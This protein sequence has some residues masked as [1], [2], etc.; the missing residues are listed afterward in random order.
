[1]EALI[2]RGAAPAAVRG[3][4]APGWEGC[5]ELRSA[6]AGAHCPR[7]WPPREG[8]GAGSH[9]SPPRQRWAVLSFQ[10]RVKSFDMPS[11]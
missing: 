2:R 8:E 4:R 7:P 9:V 6:P 3:R 10:T 1:M 5:A 11:S